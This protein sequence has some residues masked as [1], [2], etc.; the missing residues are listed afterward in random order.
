M[1]ADT[2]LATRAGNLHQRDA[3]RAS[4][5]NGTRIR[6]MALCA[7]PVGRVRGGE[8]L[9]LSATAGTRSPLRHPPVLAAAARPPVAGS[10]MAGF[11][12]FARHDRVSEHF[13]EV[14][15][16]FFPDVGGD[17]HPR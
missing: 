2:R 11:P 15:C 9:Y 1:D 7:Y 14:Q 12:G 4:V 5:S 8:A 6:S 16:A 10:P 13:F 17:A 3:R